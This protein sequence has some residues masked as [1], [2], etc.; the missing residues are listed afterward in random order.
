[1]K[2]K[3]ISILIANLFVAAPALAQ[4]LKVEGSVNLGGIYNNEDAVDPAKMNDIRDL[5]NG[6]LFGWDVKGRSS[7][8]WF[9]FFGENIGRDDMYIN[10][11]GGSYDL[12]K[13]RLYSDSLTRYQTDKGLT[14]YAGAGGAANTA[15]FPRLDPTTWNGIEVGYDRRDDGGFFEFSGASPWYFRVDANQV[16]QS[17]SKVGA[18]SQGMSPGNGYVDLAF[19]TEYKTRN[20]TGEA[21][22]ATKSMQLSLAYM[23]SR[24]DNDTKEVTF[25]NGF[26][27]NGTDRVYMPGDNDYTRF[28]AN[29]IFRQL[30][31]ASTLA[32]RYTQDELESNSPLTNTVLHGT[33][34]SSTSPGVAPAQLSPGASSDTFQGNVENKTLAIS[35]TSAPMKGLDTR[36]YYNKWERDDNS[37]HVTFTNPA[38]TGTTVY[39]NELYSYEKE[40]WG[41]DAFYRINR[42][43]RVGAGYESLDIERTRFDFDKSEEKRWFVEWKTSMIDGLS[44][45][46]KY[47]QLDRDSN[48]LLANEGTGPT[49][50]AYANRFLKAF[51]A[52]NLEQ[53][54][55][56]LTLDASP[57]EFLDLSFEANWKDNEYTDTYTGRPADTRR[58]YYA[59]LSYGDPSAYRFTVFGDWEDIKYEQRHRVTPRSGVRN[60]DPYEP[61]TSTNYTWDGQTKE[62]NQAYGL[63]LD[64]PVNEKLKL[65]A[66]WVYTKSDGSDEFNY[67]QAVPDA[68]Q[69]IN[70]T[71]FDDS[72]RRAFNLKGIYNFSRTLS[73]T[74]GWTYEKYDYKDVQID[75]Y[76]YTVPANPATGATGTWYQDSYLLGYLKDPNYKANIF[77]GW[78]TW[79]F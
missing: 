55:W 78:V 40:Y 26:Y 47:Q 36:I 77:Y 48:F 70:N 53:K 68:S 43:N 49:D 10:L 79:K 7:R 27:L 69:P 29:A 13:Y 5:T 67:I 58:E 62:S 32:I 16:T 39:E 23:V 2:K 57:V 18:A 17:G 35:L 1:M 71:S 42:Q 15:T 66:S 38:I 31:L 65:S 74:A 45:R 61:N 59:S 72:K 41:F 54:K 20:A 30:P 11:K 3:L 51:D 8:Y 21:G 64:L 9:D 73:F 50:A 34:P 12:F 44:A 22:Y 4:D 24:F 14:P 76:R 6:V 37:T 63:A 75:G 33:A 25:S 52:A 60:Y 46:L 19:P 56:K 28:S